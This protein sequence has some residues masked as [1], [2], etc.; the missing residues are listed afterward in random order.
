MRS[1]SKR[2]Q[3]G[4]EWRR[5]RRR[6][7]FDAPRVKQLQRQQVRQM[8]LP[9]LLSELVVE[10]VHQ[11]TPG[12]F[13]PR[14]IASLSTDSKRAS[15]GCWWL[16]DDWARVRALSDNAVGPDAVGRAIA[17]KDWRRRDAREFRWAC[18]SI[19]FP[20]HWRRPAENSPSGVR[21]QNCSARRR[22]A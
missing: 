22:K 13:A 4:R 12:A 14:T 1:P 2:E 20:A 3:F 17:R 8:V 7:P 18:L 16:R 10:S 19:I 21:G 9:G 5:T 15:S 6:V 11:H